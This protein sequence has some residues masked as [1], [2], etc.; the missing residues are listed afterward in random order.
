MNRYGK[1]FIDI[2]KKYSDFQYFYEK[3]L[4]FGTVLE[5]RAPADMYNNCVK[6]AREKARYTMDYSQSLVL[7]PP[8]EKEIKQFKGILAETAIQ[9]YLVQKCRIPFHQVHRWDLERDTFQSA[10]NEYDLK[11]TAANGENTNGKI[12]NGEN[13]NGKITNGEIANGEIANREVTNRKIANREITIESRASDS[14]KTSL[15]SFV[16]Q[17]DII[18]KYSNSRKTN[19]KKADVYMRPVYQFTSCM[20][21]TEHKS[22]LYETYKMIQSRE[23]QLYLVSG[24]TKEEMY[25]ERSYTKNMDQGSTIYR[26]L[27]IMDAGDM[28]RISEIISRRFVQLDG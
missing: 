2:C 28:K 27:K 12:A 15:D 17:Y 14:Y 9:L 19:E 3:E 16:R 5:F 25:G 13:T 6:I 18:G 10:S 1:E 8:E 21:K 7:R 24:A 20:N 26:C 11:I 23:L 22:K 4:D